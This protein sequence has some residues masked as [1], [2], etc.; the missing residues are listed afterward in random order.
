MYR[1]TVPRRISLN[2]RLAATVLLLFVSACSEDSPTSTS[3]PETTIAETIDT[4]LDTTQPVDEP[5]VTILIRKDGQTTYERSRG[6]AKKEGNV[7]ITS[8]TGFRLASVTKPFAAL[9]IMRLVENGQLSLDDKLS[10]HIPGLPASFS[11]ITIT[12]LLTHESGLR[13]YITENNNL[14]SLDNVTTTDVLSLIPGSGLEILEFPTGSRAKYSNT[15][16]VFLAL[17]IEQVSGKSFPAFMQEHFYDRLG[18]QDS[19]IIHEDHQMGDQGEAF[20]MAYGTTTNVFNFNSL[21]YGASGQ[22]SSVEDLAIFID[23]L[24]KGEVVRLE[25]LDQMTKTRST[26]PEFFDYGYGW[27]TGTGLYWHTNTYSSANDFWHMGGFD[28]YRTVLYF[29]PDLDLQVVVLANNGEKS[30]EQMLA[31]LKR[32]RQFYIAAQADL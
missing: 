28:G 8:R 2:M 32:A 20:A 1:K 16:Y 21:I 22:V 24:L 11:Q 26:I 6:L 3:V 18:M 30:Q 12:H 14:Q 15:G 29:N 31:I 19:Y 23:A 25:T 13:D 10:Q 4:Y 27:Q 7:P 9:G 17:V 5:G